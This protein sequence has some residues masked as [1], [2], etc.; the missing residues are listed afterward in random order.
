[1]SK[2]CVNKAKLL[3]NHFAYAKFYSKYFNNKSSWPNR[4]N[5]TI[6]SS[7]CIRMEGKQAH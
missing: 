4:S 1:M 7:I 6:Y 5:F 3:I 2:K